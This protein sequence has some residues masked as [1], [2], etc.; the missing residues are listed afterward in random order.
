M[1]DFEIIGREYL[2]LPDLILLEAPSFAQSEEYAR[3]TESERGLPSVVCGAFTRYLCR[4][5]TEID[6]AQRDPARSQKI[7]E[8]YRAIDRLAESSDLEV[9]NTLVVE[10][11]EHLDISGAA[12]DAFRARLG[13]AANALYEE[14]AGQRHPRA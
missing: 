2:R 3:L 11:Y 7:A 12:L 14:W 4:L 1:S 10:V 8:T 13:Q 6:T 9:V 5:Y